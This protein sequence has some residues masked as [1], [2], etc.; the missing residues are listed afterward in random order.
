MGEN[1]ATLRHALASIPEPPVSD[2]RAVSTVQLDNA[3][4]R[5]TEW[6][7]APGTAT[8]HH[9]HHYD[10]VVVPLTTGPLTIVTPAGETTA[11]LVTGRSYFRQAG[12]EHDV[13]NA[14]PFVFV[15]VEIEIKQPAEGSHAE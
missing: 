15:F 9:R 1:C 4:V 12:V 3:R 13:R 8:G 11:D 14:N 6:R 5:V 2:P 7:F 10:Y